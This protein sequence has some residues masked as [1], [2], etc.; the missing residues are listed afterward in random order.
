MGVHALG[1]HLDAAGREA[2][3]GG[4]SPRRGF[5]YKNGH[6][7]FGNSVAL[8][9]DGN[10]ALIGGPETI[11]TAARARR[12][13]SRALVGPGPS[14]AKSSQAAG[15]SANLFGLELG[16][17]VALSADGDAALI[18][19][20]KDNWH[21]NP[22]AAWVFTRSGTTWTQQGEAKEQRT[23]RR[24]LGRKIR[25]KRGAVRRWRHGADRRN[26]GSMGMSR[27]MHARV[28]ALW[29]GLDPAARDIRHPVG[30]WRCRQMARPRWSG[31]RC[32]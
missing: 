25:R 29:L 14:R 18:G 32:S 19:G 16:E 28:R 5:G 15:G 4:R 6:G 27:R 8:S 21:R 23:G 11:G 3:G 2:R 30:P 12:G 31:L 26:L 24:R 13:C 20:P 9:S 10:T 22:R 1:L 7:R 17:S